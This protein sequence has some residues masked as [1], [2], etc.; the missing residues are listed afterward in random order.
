M[1]SIPSEREMEKKGFIKILSVIFAV[2]VAYILFFSAF[3]ILRYRVNFCPFCSSWHTRTVYPEKPI[4]KQPNPNYLKDK[5]NVEPK[6]FPYKKVKLNPLLESEVAE[7]AKTNILWKH[8]A[9]FE[10]KSNEYVTLFNK[11]GT[12]LFFAVYWA[13]ESKPVVMNSS[14]EEAKYIGKITYESELVKDRL[15][16]NTY[17]KTKGEVD[18]YE[19]NIKITSYDGSTV[20]GTLY[21]IYDFTTEE[22]YLGTELIYSAT[23]AEW[24]YVNYGIEAWVDSDVS[25]GKTYDPAWI[26]CSFSSRI[27]ANYGPSASVRT[28]GKASAPVIPGLTAVEFDAFAVVSINFYGEGS[29]DGDASFYSYPGLP[30]LPYYIPH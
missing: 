23:A 26:Q 29:Y 15:F 24:V 5:L 8:V 1:N 10:V 9:S 16:N 2:L 13:N 27:M 30:C 7:E 20:T 25:Y 28:D 18:Y 11:N 6:S 4:I 21:H 12:N 22:C 17:Y 19:L 14:Y 3:F